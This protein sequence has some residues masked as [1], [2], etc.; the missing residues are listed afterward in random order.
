MSLPLIRCTL[1]KICGD[2][3]DIN[4]THKP[5]AKEDITT[6]ISNGPGEGESDRVQGLSG[7]TFN[8][9]KDDLLSDEGQES[10]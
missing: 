6:S 3:D 2:D 5:S 1:D 10:Q 8:H 9:S 7:S 4:F